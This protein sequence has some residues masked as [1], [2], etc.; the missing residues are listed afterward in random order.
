MHG[1]H[2]E[3]IKLH[4]KKAQT[5]GDAMVMVERWNEAQEVAQVAMGWAQEQMKRQANKSRRPAEQFRIGDRV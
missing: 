5:K 3:S 4:H 2:P 1:F